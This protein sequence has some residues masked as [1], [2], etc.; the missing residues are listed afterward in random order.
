MIYLRYSSKFIFLLLTMIGSSIAEKMSL[1]N[2]PLMQ[3]LKCGNSFIALEAN[4]R[5]T[6]IA[7]IYIN[8]IVSNSRKKIIKLSENICYGHLKCIQN[9]GKDTIAL[10]SD[11]A[12]GGNAIEPTYILINSINYSRTDVDAITGRQNGLEKIMFQH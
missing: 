5:S 9:N 11:E 12:C 6:D 1:P 7:T 10:V 8:D 3:N 2:D 4:T